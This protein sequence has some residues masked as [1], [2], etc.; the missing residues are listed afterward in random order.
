MLSTPTPSPSLVIAV[1]LAGA[2]IPAGFV[3]PNAASAKCPAE[4]VQDKKLRA[5]TPLSGTFSGS[6]LIYI[7]TEDRDLDTGPQGHWLN[8]L[9]AYAHDMGCE[10]TGLEFELTTETPDP[11]PDRAPVM[12]V[13]FF[14]AEVDYLG[15][16]VGETDE[17]PL[18]GEFPDEARYFVVE[19]RDG[20]LVSGVDYNDEF[21]RGQPADPYSVKFTLEVVS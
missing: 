9:D 8:G 6:E 21:Y 11:Y 15:E 4:G 13:Q 16:V 19:M 12:A 18:E 7:V 2:L 20:P 1:L 3:A 5:S 10:A 17:S 14:D